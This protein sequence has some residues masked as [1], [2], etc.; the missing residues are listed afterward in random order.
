ML[1]LLLQ[2]NDI[3]LDLLYSPKNC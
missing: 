1:V 2:Y 3:S